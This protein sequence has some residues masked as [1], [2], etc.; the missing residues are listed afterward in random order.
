VCV[1]V[2]SWWTHHCRRRSLHLDAR[3]TGGV[4]HLGGNDGRGRHGALRLQLAMGREI[5]AEGASGDD[6]K[7]SLFI[8]DRSAIEGEV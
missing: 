4:P 2:I 7:S 8:L 5:G 3:R 6:L 1:C